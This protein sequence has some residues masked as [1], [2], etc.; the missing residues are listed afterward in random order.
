MYFKRTHYASNKESTRMV[1][2]KRLHIVLCDEIALRM[3][4][5][6]QNSDILSLI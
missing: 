3:R 2:I 6:A 1:N 5:I 4:E